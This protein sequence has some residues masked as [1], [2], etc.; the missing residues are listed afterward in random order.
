MLTAYFDVSG[1]PGDGARAFA[2]AGFGSSDRKWKKFEKAWLPV[3]AGAGLD[4]LHMTDLVARKNRHVRHVTDEMY[5]E[6]ITELFLLLERHTAISIVRLIE[7]DD[8]AEV[9]EQGQRPLVL[10][11]LSAMEAT[12][13]WQARRNNRKRRCDPLSFVFHQGEEDKGALIAAAPKS[14]PAPVFRSTSEAIPLQAADWL[15]WE[16]SRLNLLHN[17]HRGHGGYKPV[18]IRGEVH[19]AIRHL[20]R[21][22]KYYHEGRW[23]DIIAKPVNIAD[24]LPPAL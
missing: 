5:A 6:L 1:K 18:L 14:L 17:R 22:W 7:G 10:A 19:A 11:G 3:L 15:A 16:M 23:V 20:R 8:L 4:A 12:A 21:D 2:V 9:K 24:V 13:Q